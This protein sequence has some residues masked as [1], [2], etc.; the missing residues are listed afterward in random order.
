MLQSIA[1]RLLVMAGRLLFGKLIWTPGLDRSQCLRFDS[2]AAALSEL[3]ELATP[4]L[5]QI[6]RLIAYV[7]SVSKQFTYVTV[8]TDSGEEI[9]AKCCVCAFALVSVELVGESALR[10]M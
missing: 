10:G 8:L 4:D 5:L 2:T 7:N 1:N 6:G 9:T 3:A